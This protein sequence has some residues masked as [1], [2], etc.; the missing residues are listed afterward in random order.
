METLNLASDLIKRASSMAGTNAVESEDMALRALVIAADSKDTLWQTEALELLGKLAYYKG[1]L[2]DAIDYFE[3]ALLLRKEIGDLSKVSGTINNIGAVFF[4]NGNYTQALQYYFQALKIKEDL[5]DERA[6]VSTLSNIG[7]VYQILGKHEEALSMYEKA[8]TVSTHLQDKNLIA[9]SNLNIGLVKA[10][11]KDFEDA[12]IHYQL[13]LELFQKQ[14]DKHQQIKVLNNIGVVF[15]DQGKYGEAI[16]CFERCYGMS[17]EIAYASGKIMSLVNLGETEMRSKAYGAAEKYLNQAASLASE[18]KDKESL[19]DAYLY[20]TELYEHTGKFEQSLNTYKQHIRVK[21]ELLNLENLK[22][23][24]EMQLQYDLDKKDR[25]TEIHRLKNVELKDALDKL[26]TEKNRSEKLLLNILPEEIAEELKLTG[27]SK[28]R[29]YEMATVMFIDIRNF[30]VHSEHLT[31]EELV[32]E[33]DFIFKKFDAISDVH[34]L[35]KIKTIG[36]AYMCAAGLP[37]P[38]DTNPV[39]VA[40]AAIDICRFMKELQ[41]ER[42]KENKNYFEIRTGIHTG[43]V[44]AG[45]VGS[46]KFQYDIWGDTVNVAA[47]MEQAGVAGKINVSGETYRHLQH[48]FKFTYRGKVEAKNKGAIDMYFL[49]TE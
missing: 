24:G 17:N 2:S 25:E 28:A 3:R 45:I 44:V 39:R 49:E 18:N 41:T 38:D 19:K 15:S 4:G 43:S 1:A 23:L 11:R 46:R 30:T 33:I 8:Q 37:V 42:Q 10:K 14:N 16:S 7:S 31:P 9:F 13:A 27:K 21:E 20:L 47:R 35:E 32:D 6:V 40:K 48:E 36:D 12:L 22:Q 26:Q 34:G 29:F 5:S